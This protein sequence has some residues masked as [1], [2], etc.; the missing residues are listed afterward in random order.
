MVGLIGAKEKDD[1]KFTRRTYVKLWSEFNN[2]AKNADID[3]LEI[4]KS[5]QRINYDYAVNAV[6][7]VLKSDVSRK[8][9]IKDIPVILR[10]S[11]SLSQGS[12][13]IID[14]EFGR[15]ERI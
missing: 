10:K 12:N 1:K 3:I 14:H 8:K 4:R 7:T 5:K 2:T 9:R 13:K 6:W 11:I 15:V